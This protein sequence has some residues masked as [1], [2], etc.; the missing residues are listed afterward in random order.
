MRMAKDNHLFEFHDITVKG[1]LSGTYPENSGYRIQTA[2]VL[3]KLIDKSCADYS[4]FG[5]TENDFKGYLGKLRPAISAYAREDEMKQVLFGQGNSDLTKIALLYLAKDDH[6]IK[7]ARDRV[8][9]NSLEVYSKKAIVDKFMKGLK[10]ESKDLS[11][12]MPPVR[13]QD[14]TGWCDAF[15]SADLLS[16]K[17]G[18][19]V[20]AMDISLNYQKYLEV[21]DI[22]LKR[23]FNPTKATGSHIALHETIKQGYCLE[24]DI[25]SEVAEG[26]PFNMADKL[27][28]FLTVKNNLASGYVYCSPYNIGSPF[29]EIPFTDFARILEVGQDD[30]YLTKF[31]NE[32]CNRS[33]EKLDGVVTNAIASN[34]YGDDYN[35]KMKMVQTAVD[36]LNKGVAVGF[37]HPFKMMYEKHYLES[38][39]EDGWHAS[40]IVGMEKDENGECQFKVRGTLGARAKYL[41]RKNKDGYYWISAREL[42]ANARLLFYL[43]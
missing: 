29:P 24:K 8:L 12:Q 20:S 41:G 7:S 16:Q 25:P 30:K 4:D 43:N 39:N 10:C 28:N 38:E 33:K 14:G 42:A 9:N 40:S 31:R 13:H 34:T 18:K 19:N 27:E 32:S 22:I 21:D 37:E 2:Y 26:R 35:S 23:G 1:I 5:M 36:Q 17:T 3:K 6:A 15:V 11:P